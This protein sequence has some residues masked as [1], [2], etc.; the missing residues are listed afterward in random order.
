MYLWIGADGQA[1][2]V[3]EVRLHASLWRHEVHAAAAELVVVVDDDVHRVED[4]EKAHDQASISIVR[5][6]TTVV[7]LACQVRQRLVLHFL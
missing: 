5:H 4:G 6:A 2:Y 1:A 7:T 3:L